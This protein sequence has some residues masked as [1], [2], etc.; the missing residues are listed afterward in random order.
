[1][2]TIVVSS[3]KAAELFLKTHDLA[4]A[5]RPPHEGAKHISFGQRNLRFA[6][7]CSYWCDIRKMCTLE[8][9]SNQKINSFKSMRIEEVALRVEAIRA[10]ANCGS[11]VGEQ[12]E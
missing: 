8:L 1:M 12:S 3:P 9:L 4:F 7:Y 5:S 6:E 10:A 2:P 11:I